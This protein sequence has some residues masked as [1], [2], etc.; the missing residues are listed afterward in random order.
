MFKAVTINGFTGHINE[1]LSEANTA[2]AIRENIADLLDEAFATWDRGEDSPAILTE[3]IF[4][5]CPEGE[6]EEII[7]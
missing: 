5:M 4:I 2:E 7:C 1:I 3:D 6:V